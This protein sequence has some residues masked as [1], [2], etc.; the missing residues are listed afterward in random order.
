MVGREE[1]LAGVPHEAP[2]VHRPPVG[3]R[4]ATLDVGVRHRE[5]LG[6]ALLVHRLHALRH[7]EDPIPLRRRGEPRDPRRGAGQVPHQRLRRL[8]EPRVGRS[9]A[10]ADASVTGE[11][12]LVEEG[13]ALVAEDAPVVD[14]AGAVGVAASSDTGLGDGEASEAVGGGEVS[15]ALEECVDGVGGAGA[16]R[17]GEAG[18]GG[19][20]GRGREG[21][22]QVR[23]GLVEG[24]DEGGVAACVI[25]TAAG[26]KEGGLRVGGDPTPP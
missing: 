17:G 3:V 20:G 15:A 22:A 7:G 11:R 9:A 4:R 12:S 21:G 14:D 18:G 6:A 19:A 10:V 23:E 2:G 26:V 25:L 5:A 8:G 1:G 13:R 24:G 16:L